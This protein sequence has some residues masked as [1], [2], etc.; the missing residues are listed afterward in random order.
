MILYYPHILLTKEQKMTLR[1]KYKEQLG[2][3]YGTAQ[4]QLRKNILFEL[5]KGAGLDVCYR[6]DKV[7]E[8]PRQL[9]IEHIDAWRN[10]P[11][12]KELFFD[13]KNITFSHLSCNSQAQS[14]FLP[15]SPRKLKR[16]RK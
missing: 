2:V 3:D 11:D 10:E 6:C 5:V 9:S 12:A 8:T 4:N 14:R 1:N 7:I 13:L 15:I 16:N